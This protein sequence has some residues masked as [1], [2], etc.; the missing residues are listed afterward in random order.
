MFL[1]EKAF[2]VDMAFISIDAKWWSLESPATNDC[3][4]IEFPLKDKNESERM[5]NAPFQIMK[6][7]NMKNPLK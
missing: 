7:K 3:E 5:V 4:I 1:V 2:A 6:E